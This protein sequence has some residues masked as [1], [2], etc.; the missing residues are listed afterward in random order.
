MLLY[1]RGQPLEKAKCFRKQT[2]L[3]VTCKHSVYVKKYFFES[4]TDRSSYFQVYS[5]IITSARQTHL[6]VTCKHS[7]YVNKYFFVSVTS[8]SSYFQVYSLIVTS[9]RL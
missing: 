7:V 3:N 6:N 9:A 4:V 1:C 5:F 2:H 8:T